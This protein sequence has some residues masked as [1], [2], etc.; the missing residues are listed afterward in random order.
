MFCRVMMGLFFVM[1]YDEEFLWWCV[2]EFF[3]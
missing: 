3:C 1:G 2:V